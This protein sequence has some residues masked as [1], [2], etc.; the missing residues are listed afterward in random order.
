MVKQNWNISDEEKYRILSLHE[1]FTKS[2]YILNE[3][4]ETRVDTITVPLDANWGMG[5]YRITPQQQTALQDKIFEINKFITLHKGSTVSIQIES[6]ESQVTNF[7]GETGGKKEL[8]SGQLAQLRANSIINY[9]KIYFQRLIQN[10]SIQTMPTF[11]EP[12]IKVGQTPYKK[13][14]GDLKDK[15][16]VEQYKS[17][18]YVKAIVSLSK[19]YDCIVGLEITIG[20]YPGQN[21]GSHTCDEAIF[22]LKMNGI[23][24]GEV[25]L[26][27]STLD[28]GLD[29]IEKK[30][31][32]ELVL[33][34]KKLQN[35]TKSFETYV[36]NGEEKEKNRERFIKQYAGEPPVKDETPEWLISKA[37]KS[38]YGTDVDKF[39]Q[40]L[41]TINN[42]FKT[43]GRKSDGVAGGARSHTFTIDGPKSKS[44]INQAPSDKIIFTLTPLVSK[45]GKYKIFYKEG[46]H[47]DTPWVTIKSKKQQEPLFNGEPNMNMRRGETSETILLQTDLCGVPLTQPK[48]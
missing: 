41:N 18:Q 34:N 44:I 35:V 32:K 46:S 27:N 20:Y 19:N 28:M 45:N 31:N 15:T 11:P 6:S 8:P 36:K 4:N 25:N 23:P 37:Q 2:N 10:G 21:T 48:S 29:N 3:Q 33:Y 5:K 47:S 22:E 1:S 7:D 24:I 42:S 12:I 9:L 30:Y 26:N 16:K 17:E 43:Y 39:K 13:F 14:S 38:G 40:D